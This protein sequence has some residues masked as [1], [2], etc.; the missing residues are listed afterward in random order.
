MLPPE[1]TTQLHDTLYCEVCTGIPFD[2]YRTMHPPP[3]EMMKTTW[4]VL[5]RSLSL[6]RPLIAVATSSPDAVVNALLCS[7][8]F[9]RNLKHF[10]PKTTHILRCGHEVVCTNARPCAVNCA[11]EN[12]EGETVCRGERTVRDQRLRDAIYC[13]ECVMRAEFIYTRY[14]RLGQRDG[15][16]GSEV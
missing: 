7:P 4:P 6:S 16:D 9:N 8:F 14:E 2:R 15:G 5:R 3:S 12:V 13:Q 1:S 11:L 10:D